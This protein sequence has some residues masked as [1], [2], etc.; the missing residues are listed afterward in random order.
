MHHAI[1][2]R[3]DIDKYN[4]DPIGVS[5]QLTL[6]TCETNKFLCT[7]VDTRV[8][9]KQEATVA[10]ATRVNAYLFFFFEVDHPVVYYEI[11]N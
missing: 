11:C 10:V 2:M 5:S 6:A 3:N 1:T 4:M 7:P 8:L 9:N